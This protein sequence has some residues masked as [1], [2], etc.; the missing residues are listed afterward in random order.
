MKI[1]IGLFAA[2]FFF[3]GA[4]DIYAQCTCAYGPESAYDEFKRAEAVFVGE[5]IKVKQ[6]GSVKNTDYVKF[7][8]TFKV[9]AA[10]KADLPEFLTIRNIEEKDK[11]DFSEKESYLVFVHIYEKVPF[12]HRGCCTRTG[13][14]S[15]AADDLKEFEERGEKPKRV[16][17]ASTYK[18]P[19]KPDNSFNRTRR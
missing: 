1:I 16:I 4:G 7:D 19:A 6:V 10:W 18:F 17:K 9:E 11:A 5:T 2:T 3:W 12:A 8:V 15:D 13:R 14:F